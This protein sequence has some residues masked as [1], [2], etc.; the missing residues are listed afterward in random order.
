MQL[1][2]ASSQYKDLTVGYGFMHL[3]LR[4][5]AKGFNVN[6]VNKVDN[7][8]RIHVFGIKENETEHGIKNLMPWIK[9]KN[10]LKICFN[11]DK[12]GD[13]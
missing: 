7:L 9:N 8:K 5:D 11:F 1:L 10:C 2:G 6:T 13:E 4:R 12:N 3:L